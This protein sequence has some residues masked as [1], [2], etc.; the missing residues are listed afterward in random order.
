MHMKTGRLFIPLILLVSVNASE[1]KDSRP[2]G[3]TG[4]TWQFGPYNRW[5]YTHIRE[6]LPTKNIKN[7]QKVIQPIPS[8]DKTESD[9]DI[10]LKGESINCQMLLR[11]L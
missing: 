7:N 6:I 1:I 10:I 9:L 4:E 11:E 3:I 5:S 2:D 8:I